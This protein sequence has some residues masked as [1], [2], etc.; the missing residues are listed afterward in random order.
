M[1][2]LADALTQAA[3]LLAPSATAQ[4]DAELLLM[5]VTGFSRA[6]L[7]THPERELTERQ[8]EHFQA[9]ILRRSRHEPMQ[10]ILGTQEFYGRGISTSRL[11]MKLRP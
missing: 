1:A 2:S 10:H 7:M 8:S 9:A 5:H 11:T 3:A 6:E 4:R